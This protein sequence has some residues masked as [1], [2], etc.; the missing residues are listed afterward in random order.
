MI[1]NLLPIE[2]MAGVESGNDNTALA[3]PHYVEAD[4][5]RFVNNKPEEIGGWQEYITDDPNN[6]IGLARSFFSYQSQDSNSTRSIIGTHKRVYVLYGIG[7][8]NITPFDTTAVAI[9]DGID[10]VYYDSATLGNNPLETTINSSRVKLILPTG[11]KIKIGDTIE[12]KGAVGFN[13]IT[14]TELNNIFFIRE[15]NA[16]SIGFDVNNVANASGNGGGA[17]ITLGTR[18]LVINKTAHGLS[19]GDRIKIANA[20]AVGGVNPTS[21]NAEHIID[22][23]AS[24]SFEVRVG[25]TFSTSLITGGGGASAEYYPPLP[26]GNISA[27]I[28]QGY[29]LGR[30]GLGRYGVPKISTRVTK[31]PRIW[32]F[33]K[34]GT[35]ILLTAGL[36]SPVYIYVNDNIAPTILPN[37]P[38]QVNYMFVDNNIVVC[39]GA[40]GV[41]NRI[42]WSD[43]GN[44]SNWTATPT[45]QAG[46]DDIEGADRFI[47]QANAKGVNLLFTS[48]QVYTFRYIGGN[49]VWETRLLDSDNGIIAQ[50]AR[51]VVEGTCY[52]MG[53]DNF[54]YYK[55]GSVEV[56]P[57]NSRP[58]STI[59]KHVF[60]DLNYAQATKIFCWHN[61]KFNEIWWHYPSLNSIEND[62]IARFNYKELT[63]VGDTM[64][65]TAAEY[66]VGLLGFHRAIDSQGIIY[67]HE[68]G[69]NADT[70]SLPF[71]LKTKLYQL[72]N[73]VVDVKE[74]IPDNILNEGNIT[75]QI[76]TKDYPQSTNVSKTDFPIAT[77]TDR[78]LT[79][80]NGRV[81]QFAIS[82]DALNQKWKMGN[83][84][85]II[86]KAGK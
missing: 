74:I 25:A 33:D 56:L 73:N 63:W 65:R 15:S 4:K 49:F 50:N 64:N 77:T 11:H 67:N 69:Y 16:T 19:N 70:A 23:V 35:N 18:I 17:S 29:G 26:A 34:F 58:E 12:L 86:Q 27:S 83:W 61:Q 20:T 28:G 85:M 46:E 39:L 31:R 14:T 68:D 42:K 7:L 9:A 66:P 71:S 40:D 47:S 81:W 84:N 3:T 2:V 22:V 60:Q 1:E 30:Y 45:N 6:I 13:N 24:N 36:K 75:L 78:V 79:Y 59:K 43:Q 37:A 80:N 54:L 38:T 76:A 51:I 10:N 52:W 62:R 55:G 57:S 41:I 44:A 32:Q 72:Q 8:L 82:G 21:I 53:K 5:I 48:S